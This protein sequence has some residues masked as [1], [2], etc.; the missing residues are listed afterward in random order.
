MG[1]DAAAEA[2]E[3]VTAPAQWRITDGVPVTPQPEPGTAGGWAWVIDRDR[4][5][6]SVCVYVALSTL[7]LDGEVA[8]ATLDAIDSKGLSEV[9]R[10]LAVEEPPQRIVMG[11]DGYVDEIAPAAAA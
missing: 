4:V 8:Q 3:G 1:G 10:V 2:Y 7:T 11:L 9:V 6:R 5:Y